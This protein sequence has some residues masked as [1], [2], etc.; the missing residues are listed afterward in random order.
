[1]AGPEQVHNPAS[2][3]N[4]FRN[5]DL[6]EK[7]EREFNRHHSHPIPPLRPHEHE[8]GGPQSRSRARIRSYTDDKN[9]Q[10]FP[11]LSKQVELMRSSYDC[12]VIGSGYGGAIAASRMARTGKSV[13]LL[14]RGREKWPGSIPRAPPIHSKSFTSPASSRRPGPPARASGAV[15]PLACTT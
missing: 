10:G 9:A 15:I 14:E 3:L 1:M 6:D 5:P 8:A 13:C 4:G 12:V 2:A 11:R 7:L